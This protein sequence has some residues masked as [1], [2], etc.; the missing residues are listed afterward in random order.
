VQQEGLDQ[1]EEP[2]SNTDRQGQ[3][4]LAHDK[5]LRDSN[6]SPLSPNQPLIAGMPLWPRVEPITGKDFLSDC[7]LR[8]EYNNNNNNR[9]IS[10]LR[11]ILAVKVVV[12]KTIQHSGIQGI[13]IIGCL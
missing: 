12:C 13:Q 4:P 5:T 9:I 3:S 2:G 7:G 6:S 1:A 10:N 8:F 11:V